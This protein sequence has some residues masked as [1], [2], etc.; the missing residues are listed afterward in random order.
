M[1][2]IT[3]FLTSSSVSHFKWHRSW[4]VLFDHADK[5]YQRLTKEI[6]WLIGRGGFWEQQ[7]LLQRPVKQTVKGTTFVTIDSSS[8]WVKKSTVMSTRDWI[9]YRMSRSYVVTSQANPKY[10]IWKGDTL[11]MPEQICIGR[12]PKMFGNVNNKKTKKNP[13]HFNS[14]RASSAFACTRHLATKNQ[15]KKKKTAMFLALQ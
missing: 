1:T 7:L 8:G 6:V 11:R 3:C 2:H 10:V 9:F 5:P 4:K 15:S 12:A 14:N 13:K